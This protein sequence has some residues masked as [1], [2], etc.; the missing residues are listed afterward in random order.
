MWQRCCSLVHFGGLGKGPKNIHDTDP[1]AA[2][3]QATL[4]GSNQF[5]QLG[6]A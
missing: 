4:C 5:T 1:S 2:E 3:V 6:K